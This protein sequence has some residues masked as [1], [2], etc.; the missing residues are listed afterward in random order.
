MDR[1]VRFEIPAENLEGGG[2]MP[3]DPSASSPVLVSAVIKPT[4]P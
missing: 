1:V 2:L 4:M 3:R